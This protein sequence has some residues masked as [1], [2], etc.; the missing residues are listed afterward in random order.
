MA[1]TERAAVGGAGGLI[2]GS[3]MMAV[4]TVGAE[5]TAG[6]EATRWGLD[7]VNQPWLRPTAIAPRSSPST[8]QSGAPMSLRSASRQ[9]GLRALRRRRGPIGKIGERAE[10]RREEP[11]FLPA[12]RLLRR[13]AVMPECLFLSPG[14][15]ALLTYLPPS[16]GPLA[17]LG[18]DLPALL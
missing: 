18:P 15:P 4:A 6:A 10:A 17:G 8:N 1:G 3:G 2:A 12:P 13:R 11:P 14:M 9:L 16:P 5:L 7:P